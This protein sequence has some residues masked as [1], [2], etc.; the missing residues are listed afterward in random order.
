MKIYAPITEAFGINV[1]RLEQ[2]K[3]CI[4]FILLMGFFALNW[5][6]TA[7]LKIMLDLVNL[8]ADIEI[9]SL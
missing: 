6:K 9:D 8:F 2:I 5:R 1:R 3:N 7:H 4:S